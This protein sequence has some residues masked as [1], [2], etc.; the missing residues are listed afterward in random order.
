MPADQHDKKNA[1]RYPFIAQEILKSGSSIILGYFFP[2]SSRDTDEST[3]DELVISPPEQKGFSKPDLDFYIKDFLLSPQSTDPVL[4]GYFGSIIASLQQQRPTLMLRYLNEDPQIEE[5]FLKRLDIQSISN[6]LKQF[7]SKDRMLKIL[8]QASASKDVDNRLN[9]RTLLL[10]YLKSLHNMKMDSVSEELGFCLDQDTWKSLSEE[11]LTQKKLTTLEQKMSMKI[12]TELLT[13]LISL[14]DKN[15]KFPSSEIISI[16]SGLED[17]SNTLLA[18][19]IK[20]LREKYLDNAES[21][22]LWVEDFLVDH[23]NRLAQYLQNVEL[24]DFSLP[25]P[26]I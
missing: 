20:E 25:S 15:K 23:V 9:A 7:L 8:K 4:S 14:L 21:Q 13:E 16:Y 18:A 1:F 12:A 22:G 10:H 6:V 11:I 5:L 2:K 3:Q 24:C 19:S 17:R 26:R